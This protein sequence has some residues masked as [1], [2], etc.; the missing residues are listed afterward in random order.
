LGFPIISILNMTRFDFR[1]EFIR[2]ALGPP[3]GFFKQHLIIKEK[4][5][6]M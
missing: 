6:F 3:S 1:K 5:F 4:P 2:L